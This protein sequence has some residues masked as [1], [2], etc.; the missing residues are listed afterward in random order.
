MPLHP[1]PIA[2]LV[3]LALAAGLGACA[4]N[5]ES[6]RPQTVFMTEEG[7]IRQGEEAAEEVAKHLGLVEDAALNAYVDEIGQRLAAQSARAELE[8]HF[9]IVEMNEPN[10]FALPGGYIYVSRGLLAYTNDEDELANVIG[11]EIGHVSARHSVT[12]QTRGV[13]VSP[14]FIAAGLGGWAAS[15]VSP[16]LGNVIAG[17]GALPGALA[18]AQYSR[19][20]ERQSDE[21]GQGYAAKAGWD[22]MGM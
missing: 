13:M 16:T 7:E 22:P 2:A 17:T 21:L 11:H 9:H 10:A 4:L 6:G 15:I 20:Q 3:S 12:R 19:G 8:W 18:L 5:P 1:R 14:V